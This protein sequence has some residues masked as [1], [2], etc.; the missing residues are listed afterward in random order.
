METLRFDSVR[1]DDPSVTGA[2]YVD[3]PADSL[4][5]LEGANMWWKLPPPSGEFVLSGSQMQSA[6]G[7]KNVAN[8][9]ISAM[10]PEA[11]KAKTSSNEPSSAP[12]EDAAGSKSASGEPPIRQVDSDAN[13]EPRHTILP[14]S[15]VSQV[16]SNTA[17]VATVQR[18]K[19]KRQGTR[20]EVKAPPAKKKMKARSRRI[21]YSD[22]EDEF[23]AGPSTASSLKGK[24]K[25]EA[26][27]PPEAPEAPKVCVDICEPS[28]FRERLITLKD[29]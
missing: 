22:E 17:N 15:K 26:P 4:P 27:A 24:G 23:E 20:Q 19:R 3:I 7:N 1:E 8:F 2:E 12:V 18:T 25:A 9:S 10:A 11:E 13:R 5:E 28:G 21:I 14:K 16:S 29:L 6:E